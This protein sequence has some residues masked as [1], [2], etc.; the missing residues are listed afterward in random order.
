M[1]KVERPEGVAAPK[2]TGNHMRFNCRSGMI[3]PAIATRTG[4][5]QALN[6]R[7]RNCSGHRRI[8]QQADAY[9]FRDGL[10]FFLGI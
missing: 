10:R 4:I 9:G 2:A 5:N 8:A 1:M 3:T 7:G 6:V